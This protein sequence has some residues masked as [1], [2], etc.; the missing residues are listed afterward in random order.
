MMVG[1]R[2]TGP[3]DFVHAEVYRLVATELWWL[4]RAV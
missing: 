4:L 2:S 3:D 1:Y